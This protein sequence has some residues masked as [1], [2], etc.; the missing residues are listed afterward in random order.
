MAR[1]LILAGA[2]LSADSGIPTFRGADGLWEGY[3]IDQVANQ[4]TWKKNRE[5]VH[6][7]YNARRAQL[8]EVRPNAMHLA[9]ARWQRRYE[10]VFLSQNVDDLAERA[11]CVDVVYLHG[12]LREMKCEACGHVWDIGYRG[13]GLDERCER[14]PSRKGVRPGVVLFNGH[15][16]NYAKM[17]KAF[18]SLRSE[19]VLLVIGTSGLVINV[20]ALAF[21]CPAFRILNNLEP[22]PYI[23]HDI[24]NAVIFRR[25]VDAVD[26][27]DRLLEQKLGGTKK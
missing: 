1:L 21:D 8:A 20:N 2:G 6:A 27:I 11:N 17:H 19:D 14:C 12:S 15:A 25:A 16:P 23:D 10:T 3:S 26:E 18:R 5:M 24:F 13:F 7:F 22:S 4:M 9:I